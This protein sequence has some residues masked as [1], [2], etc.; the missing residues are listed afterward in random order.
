M[1][2]SFADSMLE[3]ICHQAK[4]AT[5]ALG[6]LSAKKLRVRL[7]ELFAAENVRELVAGRP[8]PLTADRVGEFAVDLYG[9]HRLVFQPTETPPPMLPDGGIDWSS[10]NA[11]TITEIGD[12]HA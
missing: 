10:V 1:E 5:K 12:Y 8:H 2:I 3:D 4:L 11:V 9:G 7:N 6:A